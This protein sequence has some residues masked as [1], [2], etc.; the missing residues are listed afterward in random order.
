MSRPVSWGSTGGR[1]RVDDP[2]FTWKK[3]ANDKLALYWYQGTDSFA[4]AVFDRAMQAMEM[5]Q[6]DTGVPVDNQVQILIYG[7]R[8]A[9]LEALGPSVK[10]TEGGVTFSNFVNGVVLMNFGPNELE[11]G[12][13]AT[14]HEM[15]HVIMHQRINSALGNSS[16]PT[17]LDEGLAMYYETNP[18]TLDRQFAVPLQRALQ[19]DTVYRLR[20]LSG[21]FSSTSSAQELAYGQSYSIVEFMFRKYGREKIA[22]LL[23]AVK[24][25][26]H[27]EDLLKQVLGVGIDQLDNEWRKDQGLKPREIVAP[28][29]A[30]PTAFPTFSLS[31]DPNPPP[32]V[33]KSNAT[34]TPQSVAA[35]ATP[36]PAPTAAP[37]APANSNPLNTLCGG[38]FGFIALGLVGATWT[39]RRLHKIV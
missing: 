12:K 22:Q 3:Q 38:V 35:V 31:T 9:F 33:A 11:W 37:K 7:D 24:V 6:R 5:L 34:A 18:G 14:T 36:A 10:G 17:W 15:T 8:P 2:R 23:Q 13:G 28:S 32:T 19:N 4:K 25:G 21:Y 29:N 27:E 30:T 26:G 20:T 16:F 39:L 1:F